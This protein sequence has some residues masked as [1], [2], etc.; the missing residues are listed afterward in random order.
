MPTRMRPRRRAAA[1]VAAAALVA[2]ALTAAAAP[3]SATVAATDVP[4]PTTGQCRIATGFACYGVP[5][6]RAAYDLPPLLQRG[7]D[8]R[9]QRIAILVHRHLAA[10]PHDLAAFS[11]G[12]RLPPAHLQFLAPLGPQP[13]PD[14]ADP[15]ETFI[16]LDLTSVVEW[17]HAIAPRATLLVVEGPLGGLST[18]ADFQAVDRTARAILDRHL[19]D[20]ILLS[21]GEGEAALG[22]DTVRTTRRWI[23]QAA[24]QHV[25]VVSPAGDLGRLSGANPF[26]GPTPWW[27]ADDPLVTGVGTTE[28]T[29]DDHGRRTAPDRIWNDARRS[30]LPIAGGGGLSQF[31]HRPGYQHAVRHVVDNHRGAPDLAMAGGCDGRLVAYSTYHTFDFYITQQPEPAG[32][33]PFCTSG[34]SAALF[35]GVAAIAQQAAGHHLGP[36]NPRL[37]KAADTFQDITTGDN[38][39]PQTPF[40][41]ADPGNAATPGYDLVSGLGSPNADRLINTLN[42]HPTP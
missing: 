5:Q 20:V 14:P 6:I 24:A 9:D 19:A 11:T 7:L 15:L 25:P 41:P 33:Q 30:V 37:Y 28:L 35:A 34:L 32:W 22:A 21:G 36:L 38:A 2:A 10:L 12:Y 27:P 42:H 1:R 26:L 18:P 39:L 3:A 31:F 17:V 29:L 4:P 8:G 16:A 40:S 23:E 13:Q